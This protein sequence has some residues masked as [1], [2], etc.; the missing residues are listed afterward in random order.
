MHRLGELVRGLGPVWDTV[1]EGAAA[2]VVE[3]VAPAPVTPAAAPAA[4]AAAAPAPAP[5]EPPKP[6]W[7]DK[8]IAQLTA[9]LAAKPASPAPAP[10]PAQPDPTADF[11]A[12]VN[13]AAQQQAQALAATAAFNQKCNEIVEAGRTTFGKDEFN[14]SV[15]GL[16]K[17]V[18]MADAG[19]AANYTD[20][21]ETAIETGAGA[22]LLFELGRDLDEAQ[23]VLELSPKKRAIEL[24]R[25]AESLGATAEPSKAPKPIR[26]IEAKGVRHEEI[27]PADAS[28]ADNLPIA[29]WMERRNKQVAGRARR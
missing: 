13:A 20:F 4:A 23:R 29:D 27:D 3:P 12:R 25:K 21:L 22:E 7:K 5:V 2:P 17:L 1:P 14:S 10:A 9:R 8:R 11:N 15:S 6:D 16:L 26:V 24:A 28:R 19:S 18:D